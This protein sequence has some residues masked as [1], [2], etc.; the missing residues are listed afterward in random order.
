MS[1][2]RLNF[3]E[4]RII[5]K[6]HI[7]ENHCLDFITQ[8]GFGLA[9]HGEQGGEESHATINL[10]K[11]RTFGLQTEAKLRLL[12]TEHMTLVSPVLNLIIPVA[13]KRK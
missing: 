1:F 13:K 12:M 8:W 7:L 4:V 10:W 6:Q 2:Y 3:P 9:L 5:P 11:S